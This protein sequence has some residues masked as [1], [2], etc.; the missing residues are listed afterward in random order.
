MR[1]FCTVITPPGQIP[2]GVQS[3]VINPSVCLCVYLSVHKHISGTTGPL[4]EILRADRLCPWLGLP[5][6]A[7][8]YVMYFWFYGCDALSDVCQLLA[9]LGQSLMSMNACS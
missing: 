4:R 5:L 9:R 6:T 2:V 8:H 3:I 7:L 1:S